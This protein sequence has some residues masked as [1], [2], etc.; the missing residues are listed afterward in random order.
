MSNNKKISDED[1]V[2]IF[3]PYKYRKP[4]EDNETDEK[5][6]K[7]MKGN[8]SGY[9]IEYGKVEGDDVDKAIVAAIKK[10][11]VLFESLSKL[12]KLVKEKRI[13][14]PVDLLVERDEMGKM[15]FI[16]QEKTEDEP[17][18]EIERN[19]MGKVRFILKD[20]EKEPVKDK[21]KTTE[22]KLQESVEIQDTFE[23]GN[24]DKVV[25]RETDGVIK[26]VC[27]LSKVSKNN[28]VYSDL[29]LR[30]VAEK[31]DGMKVFL[32][33]PD[34]GEKYRKVEK[35]LGRIKNPYKQEDKIYGELHLLKH[36]DFI[37]NIA[38]QMPEIGIGFS[39]VGKGKTEKLSD[40]R[41][42]VVDVTDLSSVD[43]VASPATTQNL[44]NGKLEEE[45]KSQ[46][47][48]ESYNTSI[49]NGKMLAGSYELCEVFGNKKGFCPYVDESLETS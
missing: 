44:F 30:T 14:Q 34:I 43:I 13:D 8:P 17:D 4:K 31:M 12:K 20:K 16:I 19:E 7:A 35:L 25:I 26:D 5:I 46:K 24:F 21:I 28:R 6:M 29:A 40:G 41:E 10:Q 3:E 11:R 18:I 22:V 9:T 45:F 38:R 23:G 32:N 48:C 36:Q 2:E 47:V 1:I 27:L 42:N 39:I 15:R 33:H 37:L 49:C